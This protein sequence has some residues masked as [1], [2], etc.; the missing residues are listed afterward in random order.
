[1]EVEHIKDNTY[2]IDGIIYEI[3]FVRQDDQRC[4][5]DS[6]DLIDYDCPEFTCARYEKEDGKLLGVF[7]LIK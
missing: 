3:M 6:C 4:T 2:K 1:M 5:C 7:K